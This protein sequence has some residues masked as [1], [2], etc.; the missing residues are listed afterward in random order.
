[1][2]ALQRLV[3]FL[4]ELVAEP[5]PA[6]GRALEPATFSLVLARGV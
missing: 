1:M 6:R 3:A 2:T 4:G 5:R